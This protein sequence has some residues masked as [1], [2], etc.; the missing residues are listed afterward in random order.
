MKRSFQ[1]F[2]GESCSDLRSFMPPFITHLTLHQNFPDRVA[3]KKDA[4]SFPSFSFGEHDSQVLKGSSNA[5][6]YQSSLKPH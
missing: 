3:G 1:V 2:G 6:N 4:G 5:G